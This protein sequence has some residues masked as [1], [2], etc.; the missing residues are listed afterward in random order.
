MLRTC[1]WGCRPRRA[2][3]PLPPLN[4]QVGN[5]QPRHSRG[6]VRAPSVA[7]ATSSRVKA[8][9]SQAMGSAQL[10]C[11]PADGLLL[12]QLSGRN[13]RNASMTGTS[14]RASVSDTRVWQLEVSRIVGVQLEI[15]LYE[16]Y[17]GQLL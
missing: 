14:P 4:P 6:D 12:V 13:N 10:P 7:W 1:S 17:E 3:R 8:R 15:A 2:R 11:R 5:V 16:F 9:G